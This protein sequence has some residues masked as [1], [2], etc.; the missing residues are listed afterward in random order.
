V[1]I[2]VDG[3]PS[4]QTKVQVAPATIWADFVA[5][6]KAFLTGSEGLGENAG[7]FE[8]ASAWA[9]ENLPLVSDLR[10]LAFELY[11]GAT[12]CDSVSLLNVSFAL[13]GLV[14][15]IASFGTAGEAVRVSKA[16]FG[17]AARNLLKRVARGGIH[18]AIMDE[19]IAGFM[20]LATK[21]VARA[22]GTKAR[23][24]ADWVLASKAYLEALTKWLTQTV[25]PTIEAALR[26]VGDVFVWSQV[27]TQLGEPDTL[28][29]MN[30][31]QTVGLQMEEVHP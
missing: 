2:R 19:A 23:E 16:S 17:L 9:S 4:A 5:M 26:S 14:T 15:D 31:I 13:I 7:W 12:G 1:T 6:G 8:K 24:P 10:T 11:K 18:S 25:A 28:R 22:D 27:Y 30:E 20:E 21:E 3:S 29:I